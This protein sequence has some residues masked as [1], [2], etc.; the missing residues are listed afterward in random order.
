[1]RR[2]DE[3]GGRGEVDDGAPLRALLRCLPQRWQAQLGAE[4]YAG[5]VDRAKPLPFSEAGG[6][7]ILAEKQP[8]V[9]NQDVELAETG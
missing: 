3:A 8:S 5:Q 1:L 6:F 7:D 2:T 4:E 9:I